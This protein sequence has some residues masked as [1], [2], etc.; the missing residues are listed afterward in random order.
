MTNLSAI[1]RFL[2]AWLVAF[3]VWFGGTYIV[4][5]MLID[6]SSMLQLYRP[7]E[8]ELARYPVLIL[9]D[10]ILTGAFVWVYARTPRLGSW[11]INGLRFGL[12]AALLGAVPF[13]VR[14]YVSQPVPEGVLVQQLLFLTVLMLLAGL[15]VAAVY[16]R[17]R[18]RIPAHVSSSQ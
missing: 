4:N 16:R 13:Q 8:D 11:L 5:T 6:Y 15:G 14:N 10:I 18:G 2:A 17:D 7:W 1:A 9:G 12:A 3:V